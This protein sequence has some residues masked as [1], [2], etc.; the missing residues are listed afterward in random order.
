MISDLPGSIRSALDTLDR[1]TTDL[2]SARRSAALDDCRPEF[3]GGTGRGIPLVT[4]MHV[5]DF[6]VVSSLKI[7][8]IL[9][10]RSTIP[11]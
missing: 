9:P 10:I 1:A 11:S 4:V 7:S 2:R 3:Q 6:R 5:E 8:S